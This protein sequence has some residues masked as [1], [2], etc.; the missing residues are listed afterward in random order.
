[1]SLPSLEEFFFVIVL[2]I[3]GFLAF[4]LFKKIG[5]REKQLSDFE[6]VVWSLIASLPI[7]AIFAYITGLFSLD[8]IQANILNPLNIAL[9][10]ILATVFGVGSGLIARKL[11]RKG[12]TSGECWEECIKNAAEKGSYVLVYTQS[13]E[14]YMGE[15]LLGGMFEATKEIVIKNPMLIIRNNDFT[16]KDTL[17]LGTTMYFCESDIRRIAFLNEIFDKNA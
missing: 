5:I 12:I 14:E 1:M 17:E 11:F 4:G 7:Y 2:L 3:P 9:T 15:L 8:L 16:V 6:S 10:F 13:N